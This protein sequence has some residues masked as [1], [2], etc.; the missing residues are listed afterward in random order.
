MSY[1]GYN[2]PAV[3]C[4]YYIVFHNMCNCS[5]KLWPK[6]KLSF[7]KLLLSDILSQW[8]EKELLQWKSPVHTVL[9]NLG[10]KY[11]TI[12]EKKLDNFLLN[13]K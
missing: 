3:S 10:F 2:G 5:V 4:F 1:Y 9:Q 7:H 6:I 8:W 13:K 11:V 12:R